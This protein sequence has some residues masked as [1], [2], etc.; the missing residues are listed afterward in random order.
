MAKDTPKDDA[1]PVAP[2]TPPDTPPDTPPNP[3]AAPETPAPSHDM[4]DWGKE[5]SAQVAALTEAVTGLVEGVTTPGE[6]DKPTR[7]PWHRRGM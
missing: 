5:L 6:D 3:P 7:K 4:P 2:E 1:P